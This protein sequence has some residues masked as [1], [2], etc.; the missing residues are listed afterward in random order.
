MKEKYT[1]GGFMSRYK[2]AFVGMFFLVLLWTV[3]FLI[4]L[5]FHATYIDKVLNLKGEVDVFISANDKGTE[6]HTILAGEKNGIS[7]MVA[8]G[9]SG[10]KNMPE[11]FDSYLRSMLDSMASSKELSDYYLKVWGSSLLKSFGSKSVTGAGGSTVSALTGDII[12]RFFS[13]HQSPLRGLGSCILDASKRTG[14]PATIIIAVAAHESAWGK[15]DLSGGQCPTSDP[16]NNPPDKYSNNLFGYK[17]EGTTGGCYWRTWE[18]LASAPQKNLGTCQ[19]TC[20]EGETCYYIIAKFRS[21]YN[22]CESINDFADL[23]GKGPRYRDAMKYKNNPE[24][25]ISKMADAGYATNPVWKG[26]VTSIVQSFLKEYPYAVIPAEGVTAEIP[27]PNGEKG[28]IE[29][30]M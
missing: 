24:M 27:L 8:L 9:S 6:L 29:V 14:V 1:E 20:G 17:G 11:D 5:L 2:K 13:S 3:F 25:L 4:M 21:Y 30:V 16:Y 15:S 23:V 28:R 12:D 18:C 19:N 22:P 26:S 10:A 7:N